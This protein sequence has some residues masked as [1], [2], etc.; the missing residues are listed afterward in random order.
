MRSRCSMARAAAVV[1]AAALTMTGPA[2]ATAHAGVDVTEE[3]PFLVSS[4][5]PLAGSACAAGQ[6]RPAPIGWRDGT[7]WAFHPAR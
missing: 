4:G 5:T 3:F 1:L 6:E 7:C 2:T